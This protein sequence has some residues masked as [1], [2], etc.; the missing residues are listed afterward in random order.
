ML[1]LVAAQADADDRGVWARISA[2]LRKTRSASSHGEV[3]HGV[4]DPVEREAQL[5]LAALPR[6][7]Q[8][9]KDGLEGARIVVAPHVDDA[10]GDVD[11]GVD[12][13][14]ARPDAPSCARRPVRSPPGRSAAG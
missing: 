11:L 5:A 13:A 1:A 2:A 14:L 12:H 8:A 9:G 10:H 7:L 6:P 4:E 3:A